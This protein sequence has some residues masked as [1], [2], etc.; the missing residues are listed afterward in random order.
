MGNAGQMAHP[1]N[2]GTLRVAGRIGDRVVHCVVRAP[3]L[4]HRQDR[5]TTEAVLVGCYGSPLGHPQLPGGLRPYSGSFAAWNVPAVSRGIF[6]IERL[7]DIHGFWGATL[8]LTALSFPYVPAPRAGSN[9]KPGPGGRGVSAGAGPRA[10]V[11]V[12]PHHPDAAPSCHCRRRAPCITL[13][14]ERFRSRFPPP[15]RDLHLGHISP[16]QLRFRPW[17][18]RKP[19]SGPR[20]YGLWRYSFL[21]RIP[22]ASPATR[23][24]VWAAR[25]ALQW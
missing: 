6:G 13:H 24:R 19:F 18:S 9:A 21:I 12:L 22:G 8:T 25:S 3:R 10:L 11:G 5:P 23:A 2:P 15:I 14:A 4:A 7:P 17:N 20:W 16:V 1:A